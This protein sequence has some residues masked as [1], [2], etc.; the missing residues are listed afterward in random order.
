MHS[1]AQG[2]P[3]AF[4]EISTWCFSPLLSADVIRVACFP[5]PRNDGR[6]LPIQEAVAIAEP[7]SNQAHEERDGDV[8]QSEFRHGLFCVGLTPCSMTSVI[9][10]V[11]DLAV[12]VEATPRQLGSLDSGHWL[13][14]RGPRLS[15]ACLAGFLP[16][17]T[18]RL[19][20]YT[21]ITCA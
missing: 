16:R 11:I 5:L 2:H 18:A 7:G 4:R 12:H 20:P 8:Q 6:R 3:T 17:A 14:T 21:E 13:G 15:S 10:Y 9:E 19:T 1:N